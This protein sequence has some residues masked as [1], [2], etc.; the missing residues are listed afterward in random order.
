VLNDQQMNMPKRC[1]CRAATRAGLT[2]GRVAAGEAAVAV[3]VESV[4]TQIA[5]KERMKVSFDFM[6]KGVGLTEGIKMNR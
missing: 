5:R 1:C 2:G 4:A 3:G 6:R